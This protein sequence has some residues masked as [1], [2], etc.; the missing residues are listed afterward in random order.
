MPIATAPPPEPADDA[1]EPAPMERPMLTEPAPASPVPETTVATNI[2]PLVNPSSTP[3]VSPRSTRTE[4]AVDSAEQSSLVRSSEEFRLAISRPN[5]SG[6]T[7]IQ[8]APNA[9]LSLPTIRL[10]GKHH[11]KIL[12]AWGDDGARPIIRFVPD[13]PLE[14]IVPTVSS[15][16]EINHARLD[17]RGVDFVVDEDDL[18]STDRVSAFVLAQDSRIQLERCSVTTVG[19]TVDATVFSTFSG[20]TSG[21]AATAAERPHIPVV[22]AEDCLFRGEGDLLRVSRVP[23]LDARLAN[24]AVVLSGNLL[25]TYGLILPSG[26]T[27]SIELELTRL[28]VR[29]EGGMIHLES[30]ATHPTLPLVKVDVTDTILTTGRPDRPLIRIDGQENLDALAN[31]LDWRGR[32]VV[33]DDVDVYRRD[34]SALP[35]SI[36]QRFD[37]V[38]WDLA[39]GM[40]DTDSFHGNARKVRRLDATEPLWS[41]RPRDL[42][43]SPTD[44]FSEE[45][46]PRLD[47]IAQPKADVTQND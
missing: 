41:I 31:Q 20:R 35:G 6:T 9:V 38:S 11:W 29:T 12:G 19:E 30:D 14:S 37:R 8:L 32:G 15:L 43:L 47:E 18:V 34:Q 22:S 13:L 5:P 17:V 23:T 46:G 1:D 39:V 40:G 44:E 2:K 33:Y 45:R 25:H 24:S 16:F 26:A 28:H 7:T 4:P 42:R 27:P 36:P 3:P 21:R 10:G